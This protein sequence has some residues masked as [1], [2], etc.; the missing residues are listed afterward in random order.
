MNCGEFQRALPYIIE[1]GG[2][3]GQEEHLNSCPICS[4]LVA[5]LK[6]I[7]EAAKL[8][9]PM[10]DPDPRVWEGIQKHLEPRDLAARP[11]GPR[12]RL[13]GPQA[14]VR[15]RWVGTALLLLLILAGLVLYRRAKNSATQ[16]TVALAPAALAAVPSE[17]DDAQLVAAVADRAPSLRG[18]YEDNLRQVNAHIASAQRRLEQTP[19]DAEARHL[20]MLA[21]DQKAMLYQM[22]LS[23]AL[24]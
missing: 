4:D 18:L 3:A 19:E 14:R 17:Q 15:V 6:Y 20:L 24:R 23:R 1:N 7:A 11:T 16:E 10:E 8:L 21:Y 9:V 5:D 22:G 13:L 2:D 12:G